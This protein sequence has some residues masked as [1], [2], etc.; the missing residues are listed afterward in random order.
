VIERKARWER[1][2]ACTRA[3]L[4]LEI[5]FA[6]V[7]LAV[8]FAIRPRLS[9]LVL[10]AVGLVAGAL[11]HTCNR[12]VLAQTPFALSIDWD[13]DP[14]PSAPPRSTAAGLVVAVLNVVGIAV[15]YL[16]AGRTWRSLVPFFGGMFLAYALIA[17]GQRLVLESDFARRVAGL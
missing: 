2:L 10:V 14:R 8:G 12:L 3:E 13:S 5:C 15:V 9:S 4:L 11:V 17:A 16:A 6:L 1:A 7:L